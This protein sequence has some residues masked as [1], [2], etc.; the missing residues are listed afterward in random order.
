MMTTGE[1]AEAL[2]LSQSRINQFIK[3]G[4]LPF[5]WVGPFRMVERREVERLRAIPRPTGH[6]IQPRDHRTAAQRKRKSA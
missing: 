1:V 6:P 2:G 5:H 3:D 4:R